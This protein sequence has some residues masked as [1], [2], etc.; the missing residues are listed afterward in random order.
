MRF[1]D[2][3]STH[4]NIV[5]HPLGDDTLAYM[6]RAVAAHQYDGNIGLLFKRPGFLL[7]IGFFFPPC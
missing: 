6:K 7:E 4:G 3:R 5:G 2:Q 1:A